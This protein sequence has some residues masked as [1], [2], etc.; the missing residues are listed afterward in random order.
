MLSCLVGK[1]ALS[2]S[3]LSFIHSWQQMTIECEHL[4]GRDHP[5][6]QT[7]CQLLE[8]ARN[9]ALGKADVFGALMELTRRDG[10]L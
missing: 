9:P 1:K 8:S 3:C 7:E 5:V 4:M 10:S 2:Y 6:E